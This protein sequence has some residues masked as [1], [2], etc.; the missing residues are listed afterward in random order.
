MRRTTNAP[1]VAIAQGLALDIQSNLGY[2]GVC[3]G[4]NIVGQACGEGNASFIENGGLDEY[5]QLQ[6]PSSQWALKAVGLT[7]NQA[8]ADN[9]TQDVWYLY[10]GN[11]ND[12]FSATLLASG[13]SFPGDVNDPFGII[14]SLDY[15]VV[16]G[17]GTITINFNNDAANHTFQNYFIAT[18]HGSDNDSFGIRSFAGELV[19]SVPEPTTLTLLGA[20][21]LGVAWIARRRR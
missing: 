11:T 16:N 19:A 3:T 1:N 2:L 4:I 21:L 13:N 20:G 9:S 10:G 6:L 7:H 15:L 14:A 12:F 8:P 18:D 17:N 5:L